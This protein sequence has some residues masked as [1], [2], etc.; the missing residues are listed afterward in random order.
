M[1]QYGNICRCRAGFTLIEL[2]VVIAILSLLVSILLPSLT[3]ARDLARRTLCATN[4][5]G[6]SLGCFMYAEEYNGILPALGNYNL[7]AD[8]ASASLYYWKNSIPVGKNLNEILQPF[9]PGMTTWV[10]PAT[11]APPPDH[12][13][14][15]GSKAKN[16]RPS[17]YFSFMYLPMREYPDFGQGSKKVI[18]G[19]LDEAQSG[20]V[21]MQDPIRYYVI[22]DRGWNANHGTGG[23]ETYL[24][25]NRGVNPS[26][27]TFYNREE[28]NQLGAN[29]GF[30]D[31]SV[32]WYLLKDL[33]NLGADKRTRDCDFYSVLP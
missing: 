14:T 6:N 1:H 4:I 32:N 10:C 31:G 20:Q 22:F 15:D 8:G 2:L 16:I 25:D 12:V 33:T 23:Y 19:K 30:Y 13:D 18:P 17:S 7:G 9:T 26:S 3:K 28:N 24:N 5:H 21:L 29:I 11:S 27:S